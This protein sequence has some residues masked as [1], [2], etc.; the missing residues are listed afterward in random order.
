MPTHTHTHGWAYASNIKGEEGLKGDASRLIW[1]RGGQ[2]RA[3][4]LSFNM[5]HVYMVG[6]GGGWLAAYKVPKKEKK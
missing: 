4:V 2:R 5:S 6:G 1:W 3:G